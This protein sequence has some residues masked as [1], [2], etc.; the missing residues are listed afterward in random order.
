MSSCQ[1]GRAFGDTCVRQLSKVLGEAKSGV[2]STA[3][4]VKITVDDH[5][6]VDAVRRALARAKETGDDMDV[7]GTPAS[8]DDATLPPHWRDGLNEGQQHVY[9]TV[10]HWITRNPLTVTSPDDNPPLILIHGPPGT[11]KT[12]LVNTIVKAA[13]HL[14]QRAVCSA[15]AASAASLLPGGDT[16]CSKVGFTLN[17]QTDR[18]FPRSLGVRTGD[19]LGARVA[20]TFGVYEDFGQCATTT[21]P[22]A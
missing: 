13:E 2:L 8:A 7:G 1:K 22:R 19:G 17:V 10:T 21:W 15:F 6:Q 20:E 16:L 11:G 18:K 5:G 12:H 3:T 9:D 4:S 14:N